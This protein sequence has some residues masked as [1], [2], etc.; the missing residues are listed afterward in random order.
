[1]KFLRALGGYLQNVQ[2]VGQQILVGSVIVL[3]DLERH[4][5][6]LR[7]TGTVVIGIGN[8]LDLDVVL[9]AVLGH[10]VRAVAYGLFAE[11]LGSANAAAGTGL[12]A[13]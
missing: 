11:S 12:N 1:M 10:L 6:V 9:P 8:Q 2:V 13:V 4:A 5:T 7:L 3:E